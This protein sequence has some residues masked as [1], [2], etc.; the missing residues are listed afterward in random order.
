M[1][2]G[3]DPLS[4][5]TAKTLQRRRIVRFARLVER[6]GLIRFGELADWCARKP[7]SVSRDE[8]LR[9]KAYQ[10]LE[11]SVLNG[12][13]G[14][15]H[16]SRLRVAYLPLPTAPPGRLALRLTDNQLI[17]LRDWGVNPV[18]DVWAPR[19][20]CMRWLITRQIA[21]PP[22]LN[23]A[24]YPT[25]ASV[26]VRPAPASR[27][28]IEG[29]VT[30]FIAAEHAAER[31]PTQKALCESWAAEKRKGGRAVLRKIFKSK[32]GAAAPTR[33]RPKNR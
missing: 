27:K 10:D 7:G 11:Q 22:W 31:I 23:I 20:Q 21:P 28:E 13:F 2:G 8:T 16:N 30:R 5:A 25:K 33:G 14:L 4:E 17:A 32:M 12:E 1:K 3:T 9:T 29:F 15:L 24:A 6:L 26:S 19:E 18:A